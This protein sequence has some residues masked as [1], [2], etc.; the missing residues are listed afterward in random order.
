MKSTRE[1]LW[2]A[3]PG[4]RPREKLQRLGPAGLSDAELVALVLGT[5]LP[6][7]NVLDS[8]ASLLAQA[9]GV[10]ELMVMTVRELRALMGVGIATAGRVVAVSELWRR[11]YDPLPGRQIEQPGDLVDVVRAFVAMRTP[12]PPPSLP[13]ASPSTYVVVAD[14]ELRVRVVVALAHGEGDG[15]G[16]S[17]PSVV[18]RVLHEVLYRGGSA[19]ALAVVEHPSVVAAGGRG[20]VGEERREELRALR[21]VMKLAA[22]TVG[23]RYLSTVV[24]AATDWTVVD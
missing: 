7:V 5:G 19:F 20:L 11:A 13:S 24:I 21:D 4:D 15:T 6:G 18:P 3:P 22:S 2:A 8:A 16:E 14:D 17:I 9:G 10:H 23:L 1:S 12:S